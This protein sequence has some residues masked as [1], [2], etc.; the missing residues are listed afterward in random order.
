ME[1]PPTFPPFPLE[2]GITWNP[3]E[4]QELICGSQTP[5]PAAWD[6]GPRPAAP[7]GSKTP[8]VTVLVKHFQSEHI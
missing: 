8:R 1:A 7:G 6:E 4:A 5:Q 2:A 3:W